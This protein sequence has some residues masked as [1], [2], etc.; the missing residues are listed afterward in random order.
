MNT[1][2]SGRQGGQLARDYL[3]E[4]RCARSWARRVSTSVADDDLRD[5]V[6]PDMHSGVT[7]NAVDNDIVVE[8]E[9]IG[10][11]AAYE[12]LCAEFAVATV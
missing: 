6:A 1:P 5:R 9:M 4:V 7:T 8:I 2:H 3:P 10:L 12:A 11:D